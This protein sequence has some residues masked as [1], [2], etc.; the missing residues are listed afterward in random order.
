M[1]PVIIGAAALAA[2]AAGYALGK[3]DTPK[4]VVV[5]TVTQKAEVSEDYVKWQ[6]QHAGKGLPQGDKKISKRKSSSG[7]R[8]IPS[9]NFSDDFEKIENFLGN[10]NVDTG[11]ISDALDSIEQRAR[12]FGNEKAINFVEYYRYKLLYR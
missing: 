10:P 4:K 9:G 11:F 7:A 5:N 3:S 2:G 8:F 12:N 6:L 1:I